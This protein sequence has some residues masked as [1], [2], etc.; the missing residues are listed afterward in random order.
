MNNKKERGEQRS[1]SSSGKPEKNKLMIV[2][3]ALIAIVA[4]IAVSVLLV[5]CGESD[6]KQE[7]TSS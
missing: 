1:G 2:S 7:N 4:V 5:G 6:N 3:T